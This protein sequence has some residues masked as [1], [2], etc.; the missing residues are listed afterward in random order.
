MKAGR[1][2]IDLVLGIVR[3]EL[4][5]I[6]SGPAPDH[7]ISLGFPPNDIDNEEVLSIHR[8]IGEDKNKQENRNQ[9][10][11]DCQPPNYDN[12]GLNAT[13][14]VKGNGGLCKNSGSV[15]SGS[16]SSNTLLENCVT[17]VTEGS[18]VELESPPI[19][20]TSRVSSGSS[21]RLLNE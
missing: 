18:T 16:I 9:Q 21:N 17:A 8:I 5:S 11:I 19:V 6:Y 10:S 15:S 13:I 2:C 4:D 7:P 1:D 3:E 20:Y 14:N 12:E